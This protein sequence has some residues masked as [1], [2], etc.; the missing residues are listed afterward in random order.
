MPEL[1]RARIQYVKE[2]NTGASASFPLARQINNELSTNIETEPRVVAVHPLP[3]ADGGR[4]SVVVV[5]ERED[6]RTN[7]LPF[8]GFDKRRASRKKKKEGS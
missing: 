3:D 1:K 7:I 8:T 5:F 6:R 2:Y 4:D